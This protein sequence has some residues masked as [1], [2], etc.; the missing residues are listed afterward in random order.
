MVVQKIR[1]CPDR[2][3]PLFRAVRVRREVPRQKVLRTARLAGWGCGR[4]DPGM[5]HRA[6]RA[7]ADAGVF[8][9]AWPDAAG[10][11][12]SGDDARRLVP[13]G[14]ECPHEGLRTSREAHSGRG[15]CA[16]SVF[17]TRAG[18]PATTTSA[19]TSRVTTLPAPTT[20]RSPMVTPGRMIAPPPIHTSF[21]LVT[22]WPLSSPAARVA[23][24]SGCVAV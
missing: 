1:V 3:V 4:G 21:P 13:P 15:P 19:G 7:P 10:G 18:F 6:V 20:A 11:R 9:Q 16:G 14:T 24:S 5:G 12:R 22:G 8:P 17:R 23:A 2:L